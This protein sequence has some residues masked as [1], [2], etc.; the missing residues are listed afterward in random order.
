M[1]ESQT[2]GETPTIRQLMF[3][4]NVKQRI[5]AS[6]ERKNVIKC[7]H[8]HEGTFSVLEVRVLIPDCRKQNVAPKCMYHPHNWPTMYCLLSLLKHIQPG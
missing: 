2:N 8:H 4:P 5:A 1:K 3:Q 7:L 6:R